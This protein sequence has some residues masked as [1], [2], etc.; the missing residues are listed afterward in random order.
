MAKDDK[1]ARQA[2]AKKLQEQIDQL[3]A[4]ERVKEEE[5]AAEAK[6]PPDE[7]PREF[8]HRRMAELERKQKRGSR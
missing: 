5:A 7:S 4:A 1:K 6:A 8:I 2:R 3:K